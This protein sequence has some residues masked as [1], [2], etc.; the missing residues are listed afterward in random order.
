MHE[1]VRHLPS[2]S[3][4]IVWILILAALS[5]T[6]A[7]DLFTLSQIPRA[8]TRVP[9]Q[10]DWAM[11][12]QY[13]SV[14][15]G[16]PL[17]P[18]LW[19]PY[20]G[21]RLLIPRLIYF[22]N[23][24][25]ASLASLTWFTLLLQSLL[26]LLFLTL[27]WRLLP[28]PAARLH[29]ALAAAVILNLM[30]SAIQMQTFLWSIQSMFPL[31]YVCAAAAFL[32][33]ALGE[34]SAPITALSL[35]LAIIGLLTMLNGILIVPVMAAQA[36]YL[37][38]S[39]RLCAALAILGGLFI[40]IYFRGYRRPEMGM[41]IPGMLRHPWDAA[42]MVGLL[43][44]APLEP[45]PP[46]VRIG[47]SLIALAAAAYLAVRLMRCDPS[48]RRW[49]SALFAILTFLLLSAV[50]TVAGRLG[51]DWLSHRDFH[52]PAK[53]CTMVCAFWSAIAIL[54]L[55][56]WRRRLAGPAPALLWTAFFGCLMFAHP[57]GSLTAAE[58]WSDFFR[59][60]D[61]IGSALLLDVHDDQMLARLLDAPQTRND[62]VAFMRRRRIGPFAEPRA[63]WPGSQIGDLFRIHPAGECRGGVEFVEPVAGADSGGWRIEGW[64]VNRSSG[65][66]LADLIVADSSGRVA[67]M[68]RG[69]FR[70]RYIPGLLT[71][72]TSPLIHAG[73]RN[74]EW[75]GYLR[76]AGSRPWTVYG[77]LGA[78]LCPVSVIP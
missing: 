57:L 32:L 48:Q 21:H 58:D 33:L 26:I 35:G 56:A 28:R 13:A 44:G 50:G 61:A 25:W 4:F 70:H 8:A 68:A 38:R 40:A 64:A 52:V 75:L 12:E 6:L 34:H 27:A 15:H 31:V 65:R 77:V 43:L 60:A 63:S 24:R 37:R 5:A 11:L 67:G 14:A 54:V 74:S 3:Y 7:L 55:C 16:S 1:T 30:F 72:A 20:W 46:E 9:W 41:G 17:L 76:S 73:V 78:G 10:D 71:D 36:L 39:P 51:S 47:A 18:M 2:R 62:I 69:G 66:P 22:A 42:G 53:Y 59:G 29:F 45:W 23:V 19:S 49:L